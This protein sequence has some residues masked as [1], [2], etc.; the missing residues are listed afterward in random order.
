M[1]NDQKGDGISVSFLIEDLQYH[2]VFGSSRGML[3]LLLEVLEAFA[4]NCPALIGLE[5]I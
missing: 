1:K 5:I 3:K 4:T 2:V